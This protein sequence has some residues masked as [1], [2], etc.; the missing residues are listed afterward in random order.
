MGKIIEGVISNE[1]F[2]KY[3]EKQV[4]MKNRITESLIPKAFHDVKNLTL[5]DLILEY[6]KISE[7][8]LKCIIVSIIL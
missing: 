4:L 7:Y 5:F 2:K 3:R 1:Y 6:I 8:S